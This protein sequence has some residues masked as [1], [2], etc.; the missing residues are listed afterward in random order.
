MNKLIK[1]LIT[2]C[3]DYGTWENRTYTF[4]KEKFAKMIIQECVDIC[5]NENVSNLDMD[6]I[7][8]SGKLTVQDLATRSCGENLSKLIK[9]RFGVE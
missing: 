9:K 3:E 6:I 4:D 7:R 8:S 2:H 5:M 1:N